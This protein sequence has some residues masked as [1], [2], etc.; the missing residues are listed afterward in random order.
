MLEGMLRVAFLS[1]KFFENP[2]VKVPAVAKL[3]A[4]SLTLRI[5]EITPYLSR[6]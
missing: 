6:I 3:A 1:L 5:L 4:K 2:A